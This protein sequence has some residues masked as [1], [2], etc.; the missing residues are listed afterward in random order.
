MT[1]F[2]DLWRFLPYDDDVADAEVASE[3]EALQVRHL[4][5][6]LDAFDLVAP[7]EGEDAPL[8]LYQD[9]EGF[10]AEADPDHEL[11]LQEI[12]E[13]QHYAFEPE[14][15]DREPAGV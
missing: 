13:A 14:R 7:D 15:D 9:E 2:P 6:P 4:I 3:V 1:R 11:D 8:A 5:D 12:L 10:D